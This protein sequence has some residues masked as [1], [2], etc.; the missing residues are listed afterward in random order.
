MVANT[1]RVPW[2]RRIGMFPIRVYQ[3]TLAW[4]LGG[5]C[6]F[7]PSC[8]VYGLEA[9]QEH[10]VL[11]G[12]WLAVCRICRCHPFCPGGYDPVPRCTKKAGKEP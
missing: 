2:V 8:S 7:T 6:R 4:L 1:E 12:W 5:H 10:G 11:K 3:V 9:I